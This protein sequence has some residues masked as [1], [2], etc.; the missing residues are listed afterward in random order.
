M[1]REKYIQI[2]PSPPSDLDSKSLSI[3]GT[4]STLSVKEVAREAVMKGTHLELAKLFLSK[5]LEVNDI[6]KWFKNEI[7]AWILDLLLRKQIYRAM[8]IFGNMGA[9]PFKEMLTIFLDTSYKELRQILGNHLL[10]HEKLDESHINNWHLLSAIENQFDILMALNKKYISVNLK[11][12][13]QESDDWRSNIGTELFFRTF[14]FH[15]KTFVN[16]KTAWSCLLRTNIDLLK[17]W[18]NLYY[19]ENTPQTIIIA[20]NLDIENLDQLSQMFQHLKID[21]EMIAQVL[22]EKY[23]IDQ[24]LK[25]GIL[26]EFAKFGIFN[27]CDRNNLLGRIYGYRHAVSHEIQLDEIRNQLMGERDSRKYFL[28]RL[29]VRLT[30]SSGGSSDMSSHSSYGSMANSVGSDFLESD[31]LDYQTDLLEVLIR[32]HNSVDPPKALLFAS[33]YY[34]SSLLAVLA[35]SYEPDSVI[36]NWVTWLEVSCDIKQSFV[37]YDSV[38]TTDAVLEMFRHILKNNYFKTLTNS[39]CIFLPENP[40]CTFMEFLNEVIN[41][42][43]DANL[44]DLLQN[45]KKKITYWRSN[46]YISEIDHDMSYFNNKLWIQNTA[47][48]LLLMTL[49]FGFKCFYDQ[50]LFLRFLNEIDVSHYF[51]IDFP[52]IKTLLKIAE[53]MYEKQCEL[54]IDLSVIGSKNKYFNAINSYIND[55]VT[56]ELYEEALDLA[57]IAS[58]PCDFIIFT[59][60]QN[61]LEYTETRDEDFWKKWDQIFEKRNISADMVVEN[62]L[63]FVESVKDKNEI[64]TILKLAFN[65]TNK[66]KLENNFDVEKE[67]WLSFLQLD[68]YTGKL[69]QM[70]SNETFTSLSEYSKE[71][72]VIPE[73][74]NVLNEIEMEHFE[75][76][77]EYTL[78]NGDIITSLR[79][80]RIFGCNSIDLDILKLCLNLVEGTV[81]PYQLT[82]RQRL[83]LNRHNNIKRSTNLRRKTYI[84]PNRISSCASVTSMSSST[85]QL[86]LN[87]NIVTP[88]HDTL[89]LLEMLVDNLKSGN[90]LASKIFK[91][92]RISVN[93]HTSYK[94][95]LECKQPVNILRRALED[96]FTNKLEVVSDFIDIFKLKKEEIADLLYAEISTAIA[97]YSVSKTNSCILWDVINMDVDFNLI[98]QLL[99]DN[100]SVLGFKLYYGCNN[101]FTAGNIVRMTEFLIRC[102]DCFTADCNM[103]GISMVLKKCKL[104]ASMLEGMQDY[105]LMVRLLTGIGRYTEM[106]YIFHALKQQEQ[107]ELLLRKGS[108]KDGGLKIALLEYLKKYCPDDVELYKIVALH[109]FL[110]SEIAE[111][112]EQ[113]AVKYT[114]RIIALAKLEMQNL[115]LNSDAEPYVLLVNTED[116]KKILRKIMTKYSHAAEYHLHGQK[117][118]KAMAAA[119]QAQL[120]ALQLSLYKD[121]S[122]GATAI[123]ILNLTS[124]QISKLVLSDFNFQQ[125]LI[126]IEAYNFEANWANILFEQY[127]VADRSDFF[128]SFALS[129]PITESLVHD[130]SRIYLNSRTITVAISKNMHTILNNLNSLHAKYRIASE[131]GFT[132]IVEELLNS[133]QLSYLKDTVWKSGYKNRDD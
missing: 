79:L 58:V 107:F 96:Y 89:E 24:K 8:H 47:I 97:Q 44:Q 111:L 104:F 94:E 12:I 80:E 6:N 77:I 85:L 32:C 59:Q 86:Y 84:T 108:R 82:P 100:C 45:F 70:L 57:Q 119:K 127:L 132:D 22:D 20:P 93:L 41:F 78:S 120:V 114:R 25:T 124:A 91:T 117:L 74:Y 1:Y 133:Q 29:G 122:Q 14:D 37:N 65:W 46:S 98:L 67:L 62:Y 95:I 49:Q 102:H 109:F 113:E 116:N 53:Y 69:D 30:D 34:K 103:E 15:L 10:K 16:A 72:V 19:N 81:L 9:D 131:L 71:L 64:Y 28:S 68:D 52:D 42:N 121:L 35:N 75:K 18:I 128:Q 87:D 26:N 43:V 17:Y 106:T 115:R 105:N 129:F 83:L 66:Y 33:K 60:L 3:W 13:D 11:C 130:I 56:K 54:T 5:K 48:S 73:C 23:S 27:N 125:I 7:D 40:V 55:L 88:S 50:I 51:L 101:E 63:K 92:Y 36:M 39:F 21:E 90:S 38:I 76:V 118:T 99:P 61:Q 126:V 123:C 4:W 110:F 31:T 112:W 2:K